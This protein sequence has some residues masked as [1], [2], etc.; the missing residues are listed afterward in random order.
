MK[1]FKKIIASVIFTALVVAGVAFS[2]FFPDVIVTSPNGVWTDTRAY[3][4]INAAVAAIGANQRD[5]YIVRNEVTTALTIPA[6]ASLHFLATGAISN[7]GQLTI[8]TKNIY[9]GSYRIFSGLGDID[10]ATGSI[11]NLSWFHNLW[12]ALTMTSDD[13]VTLIIDKSI[14]ATASCALGNT[15]SL[16]WEAPGNIITANAGVTVSNIGHIE[17]GSYQILAGAGNFRFRDGTNLN[18]SWFAHLRTII[19]WVDTNV[20]N[21]TLQ[22][23]LLVDLDDTVPANL[24]LD[25]DSRRG[26][27]SISP[28]VTLTINSV[29]S[30]GPYQWISGTGTIVLPSVPFHYPEWY[31]SG[32]FTSA[33]LNSAITAIGAT[34]ANLFLRPGTWAIT[35]DVTIPATMKLITPYGAISTI[36]TTK[37]LTINGPL[38]AGIYQVFSCTGTGK[39]VYPGVKYPEWWGAKDDSGTTDNTVFIQAALTAGGEVRITAPKGGYY[40][41]TDILTASIAGTKIEGFNGAE[42]RQATAT[43]G[44]IVST[45]SSIELIGN[46]RLTGPQH[47]AYSATEIGYW[48]TGVD[49][50][51]LA[52]T[53]LSGIKIK[54]WKFSNWGRNGVVGSYLEDF[55]ISGIEVYDAFYAGIT[56]VSC[57]NG[58]IHKTNVH[59]IEGSVGGSAYGISLSSNYTDGVTAAPPCTGIIVSDNLVKNVPLWEGLDTH[60]GK[61]ISFLNNKVY[62]TKIGLSIAGTTS[63]PCT[64]NIAKG[65]SFIST[66]A[67]ASG[68]GIVDGGDP[69][70]ANVANLYEGNLIVGYYDGIYARNSE[71][72]KFRANIIRGATR[73][74]AYLYID[75]KNIDLSGNSFTDFVAGTG[76]GIYLNADGTVEDTGR[77]ADNYIDVTG[78]DYGIY[79]NQITARGIR[80]YNNTII[81]AVTASIL[82]PGRLSFDILTDNDQES[83]SGTGEDP[84]GGAT[85]YIP[86]TAVFEIETSGTKT[87]VGGNKTLKFHYGTSSITFVPAV[88]G[89][90]DWTFKAII[91]QSAAAVQKITWVSTQSDSTT[92]G[93][94]LTLSGYE[95]WTVDTTGSTLIKLTGECSNAGDVITKETLVIKRK[96]E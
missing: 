11:L 22:G 83:T 92:P 82:Y 84:I 93:N 42:I 13:T 21:L 37:T 41:I 87:G 9:A 68:S 8:N 96:Y 73:Y 67:L 45:A 63:Y 38:D 64:H 6:T 44:G 75:F 31:S 95:A 58:T 34:P 90:L 18:S 52:P 61:R 54:G 36:A 30:A 16:K 62:D 70:A 51:P 72:S 17:A 50:T 29:I 39:V 1:H 85:L 23:T 77:I 71:D 94:T 60:F 65:N 26:I 14:N 3:T 25:I 69:A 47:A 88:A 86:S 10:F 43:K 27:L 7:S 59:D 89:I 4:T 32:T 56:L 53:Y 81:G 15:V 49:N 55:D 91:V 76:I 80:Q 66:L 5:I 48:A 2:E 46:G 33:V 28:G 24:S 78:V 57:K 20:V 19:T 40:K 12:N 79:A 35:A 74:G